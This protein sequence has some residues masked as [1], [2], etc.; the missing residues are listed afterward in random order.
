MAGRTGMYELEG[1]LPSPMLSIIEREMVNNKKW[2]REDEIGELISIAGSIETNTATLIGYRTTGYIGAA[3]STA[4]MILPS[5]VV[6]VLLFR[7]ILSDARQF[8]GKFLFI[9]LN[10]NSVCRRQAVVTAFNGF[11]RS[12][13]HSISCPG[14]SPSLYFY[15]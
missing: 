4:G 8:M 12:S 10:L 14:C 2:M 3:V 1:L 6:T 11:K 7:L 13:D 9:Y 15:D 5:L